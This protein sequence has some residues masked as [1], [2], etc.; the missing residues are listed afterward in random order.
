V[1]ARQFKPVL[2]PPVERGRVI[3]GICRELVVTGVF[4]VV[5]PRTLGIF[6]GP[7]QAEDVAL[8]I[9][10]GEDLRENERRRDHGSNL[11]FEDKSG[12]RF[13]RCERESFALLLLQEVGLTRQGDSA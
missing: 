2:L 8:G 13:A 4:G 3:A 12:P 7:I 1:S 6:L 10:E 5:V 11:P 9:V